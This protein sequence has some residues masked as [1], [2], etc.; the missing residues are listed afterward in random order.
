M[1]QK[2]P[3]QILLFNR[4]RNHWYKRTSPWCLSRR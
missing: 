4:T 1:N 3:V 2:R